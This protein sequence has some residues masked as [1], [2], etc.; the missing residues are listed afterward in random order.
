MLIEEIF[1]GTGVLENI[2]EVCICGCYCHAGDPAKDD[3]V[4][5]AVREEK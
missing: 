5:D 2:G 1:P 3:S 4:E